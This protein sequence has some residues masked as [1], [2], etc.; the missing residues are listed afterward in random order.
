MSCQ[1]FGDHLVQL[2]IHSFIHSPNTEVLL[3]AWPTDK[4]T[5]AQRSAVPGPRPHSCQRSSLS[6]CPVTPTRLRQTLDKLLGHQGGHDQVPLSLSPY[7]DGGGNQAPGGWNVECHKTGSTGIWQPRSD[8]RRLHREEVRGVR[9]REERD[10]LS[11]WVGR[12]V[13][14]QAQELGAGA[15][16]LITEPI[17][18]F[19]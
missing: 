7:P 2:P 10:G 8:C 4:Q 12:S 19:S 14:G 13:T 17:P 16:E 1:G 6:G 11:S 18:C 5:E 15:G 9:G 3:C